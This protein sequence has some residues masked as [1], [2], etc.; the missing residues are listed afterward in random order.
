RHLH[1][2]VS[3]R[4]HDAIRGGQNFVKALDGFVAFDLSYQEWGFAQTSSCR[5]HRVDISP[6]FHKRLADGVDAAAQS[7]LKA[8]PVVI[9][10]GRDA[11]VNAWK[12]EALTRAKFAAD[13]NSATPLRA[14][15]LVDEQLHQSVVQKQPITRFNHVGER[16][17]AHGGPLGIAGDV[18]A[19][20]GKRITGYEVDGIGV[21]GSQPHFRSREIPHD[22]DTT[23]GD[24]GSGP[25]P[26]YDLRVLLETSM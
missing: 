3:S 12:I 10:K 24:P 21:D 11:K 18:F 25:D 2:E 17:E 19:G 1:A 14:L 26:S 15:D 8:F 22:C 20:Q 5:P 6:A 23:P 4:H 9:R 7:K 16:F 13:G